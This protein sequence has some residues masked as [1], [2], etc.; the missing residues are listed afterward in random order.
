MLFGKPRADVATAA[1]LDREGLACLAKAAKKGIRARGAKFYKPPQLGLVGRGGDRTYMGFRGGEYKRL[2]SDEALDAY[3]PIVN[4]MEADHFAVAIALAVSA[5]VH[6]AS[7]HLVQ[8][9][10]EE[11]LRHFNVKQEVIV[12]VDGHM[13]CIIR[14]KLMDL[15][16][17][18]HLVVFLSLDKKDELRAM[19]KIDEED[20]STDLVALIDTALST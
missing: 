11:D 16:S 12:L 8:V 15:R 13:A 5:G 4:A 1:P 7:V 20:R 2:T 6:G 14:P 18:S 9:V 19:M 3:E 10:Y 17:I